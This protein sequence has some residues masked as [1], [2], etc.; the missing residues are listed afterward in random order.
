[1]AHYMAINKLQGDAR[2][3][4]KSCRSIWIWN[5]EVSF[6]SL[7]R[8]LSIKRMRNFFGGRKNVQ[9]QKAFFSYF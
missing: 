8:R 1:M 6:L 5:P 4:L 3:K 2:N 9:F 7:R